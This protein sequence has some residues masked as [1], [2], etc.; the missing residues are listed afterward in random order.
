[1][2][3]NPQECPERKWC[4][5]ARLC[6]GITCLALSRL[7]RQADDKARKNPGRNLREDEEQVKDVKKWKFNKD[8]RN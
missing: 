7:Y 1:M 2:A 5:H 3:Q 6:D 8:H 4:E